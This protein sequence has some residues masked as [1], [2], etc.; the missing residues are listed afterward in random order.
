[1]SPASIG[2]LTHSQLETGGRRSSRSK[3]ADH[4][5]PLSDLTRRPYSL[6]GHQFRSVYVASPRG[7]QRTKASPSLLH[8]KPIGGDE[9]LVGI[10]TSRRLRGAVQQHPCLQPC[11]PPGSARFRPSTQRRG[12][13]LDLLRWL[14]RQWTDR[15][16]CLRHDAWRI[17][18]IS[19]QGGQTTRTLPP[20]PEDDTPP[21]G[22]STPWAIVE[23]ESMGSVIES[24]WAPDRSEWPL[25]SCGVRT[26]CPAGDLT[27]AGSSTGGF[28]DS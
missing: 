1:M 4:E 9:T 20:G 15:R 23:S 16:G 19:F 17:V 21:S 14:P 18:T 12:R 28:D 22:G 2:T 10:V 25:S 6:R 27:H 7:S 11:P 26:D 8:R 24:T 5:G 3:S 13:R